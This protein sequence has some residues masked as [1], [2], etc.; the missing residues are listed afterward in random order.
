M[1]ITDCCLCWYKWCNHYGDIK[2]LS[3]K[4]LA[5]GCVKAR[6]QNLMKNGIQNLICMHFNLL[7]YKN[8]HE[9]LT[10]NVNHHC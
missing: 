9:I 3:K 1:R 7:F 6:V 5:L 8:H 2:G 10:V 4:S